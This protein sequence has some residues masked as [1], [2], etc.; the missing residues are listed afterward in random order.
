LNI[1]EILLDKV[2]AMSDLDEKNEI[3]LS[4]SLL[5][6]G[7]LDSLGILELIEYIEEKWNLKIEDEEFNQDNFGSINKMEKFIS[8]K[9][10]K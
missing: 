1:E 3:T 5:D 2:F 9:L 4:K 6:Q 10:K 8:A 7:V